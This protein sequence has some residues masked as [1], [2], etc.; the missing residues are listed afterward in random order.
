MI[1]AMTSLK[2]MVRPNAA[3]TEML[4]S[5]VCAVWRSLVLS[6][7]ELPARPAE[8]VRLP[9]DA[10]D[11]MA[12][13]AWASDSPFLDVDESPS[14]ESPELEL[15]GES[16]P[17]AEL[18]EFE[19]PFFLDPPAPAAPA[20]T[21]F[22][23]CWTPRAVTERFFAL[24]ERFRRDV[25]RSFAMMMPKSPPTPTPLPAACASPV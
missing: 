6:R 10:P 12:L 16:P 5:E 15:P 7:M 1:S 21:V 11:A 20:F 4:P 13:S 2:A 8:P 19:E 23:V 22:V 25:V 18:P 3:A 24:M 17:P 14:D 9:S